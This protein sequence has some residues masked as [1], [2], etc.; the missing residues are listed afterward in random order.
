MP[1]T[2]IDIYLRIFKIWRARRF[3]LFKKLL[4]P[5]RDETLVDVG[6]HPATWTP[7]PPLVESIDIIDVRECVFNP[8][9]FPDH[10]IKVMMGNGCH[11]AAA[12]QSYDIAF[13]NSVIE[14]VGTWNDQRKF[15]DE[16]R[17]VGGKVWCQTPAWE[18]PVRTSLH[19][20]VH[21]LASQSRA[22]EDHPTPHPLG[23][24]VQTSSGACRFHGQHDSACQLPRDEN[25]VS[26][27]Q[28]HCRKDVW[29]PAQILYRGPESTGDGIS[30]P[31]RRFHFSSCSGAPGKNLRRNGNRPASPNASQIPMPSKTKSRPSTQ[32]QP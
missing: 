32:S 17:R 3:D 6:G 31:V 22:E 20:A 24:A 21:S 26:G 25:F 11:L 4:A 15:A 12:D 13:S 2:A 23:M 18:C 14:H 1:L 30:K 10:R 5:R 27:L 16:L 9:S 7:H 8:A 28:D 19:G 29:H